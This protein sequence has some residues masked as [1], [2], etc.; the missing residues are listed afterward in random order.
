MGLRAHSAL[1]QAAV[2]EERG[3]ETGVFCSWVLFN[4]KSPLLF[5]VPISPEISLLLSVSI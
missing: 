3:A 1:R 4:M 5:S 2:E